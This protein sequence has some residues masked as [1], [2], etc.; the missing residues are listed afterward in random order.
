SYT[1]C[2]DTGRNN[3]SAIYFR[4]PYENLASVPDRR[5]QER[6]STTRRNTEQAER[7]NMGDKVSGIQRRSIHDTTERYDSGNKMENRRTSGNKNYRGVDEDDRIRKTY[8]A[9]FES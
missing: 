2:M 1:P 3:D 9:R 5:E 4:L 8:I 6:N 7:Q